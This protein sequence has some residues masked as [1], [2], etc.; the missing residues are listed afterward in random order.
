MRS[1][2]RPPVRSSGQP[3]GVALSCRRRRA[4][5]PAIVADGAGGAIVAWQDCAAAST[6]MSTPSG[7]RP[8]ARSSGRPTAWSSAAAST[9]R[10]SRR[11]SGRR[12][13]GH[14]AWADNRASIY[15]DIYAQKISSGGAV[16]WTADGVALS[17]AAGQQYYP[18]IATDGAGGAIVAWQDARS[19]GSL[20]I[21]AQRISTA[22]VVQW[23]TDG[24]E[25]CTLDGNQTSPT[26]AADGAGGATSPGPTGVPERETTSTSRG[27]PQAASSNGRPT[28]APSAQPPATNSVPAS[29]RTARVTSSWSGMTCATATPTS[30]PR[31]STARATMCLRWRGSRASATSPATRAARSA[32]RGTAVS[33]TARPTLEISLYGIWR[34]AS[35]DRGAGRLAAGR[36]GVDESRQPCCRNPAYSASPPRG[37]R[38]SIGRASAPSPH[39]ASP[40]IRSWRRRCRTPRALAPADHLHGG[41]PPGLQ[42][43][44]LRFGARLGLLGGQP[45]AG[46][47]RSVHRSLPR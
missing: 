34:Q 12:G 6:R 1:G 31:G 28:A 22:G 30:M 2:S 16:Q 3:N 27:S 10:R 29:S 42:A 17:T 9:A 43:W 21:Y 15:S 7:F 41:C 14:M 18:A 47:A 23:T 40:P 44:I 24:V 25:I 11:R 26:I 38:R 20:D 39:A 35:H 13:R 8:Q 46:L 36:V 4:A 45:G 33:A 5:T 19:G 32:W 37:T